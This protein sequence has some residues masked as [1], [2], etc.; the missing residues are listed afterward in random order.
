M[1]LVICLYTRKEREVQPKL[2]S[3][4]TEGSMSAIRFRLL[5]WN[6]LNKTTVGPFKFRRI[7]GVVVQGGFTTL[8]GCL[9]Y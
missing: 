8:T 9:R 1:L 2:V 6:P 3:L 7:D 5:Q 4:Q